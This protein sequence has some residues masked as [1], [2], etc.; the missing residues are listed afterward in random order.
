MSP[1]PSL[2]CMGICGLLPGKKGQSIKVK[3]KESQI[4]GETPKIK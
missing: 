3:T 4:L 1:K 2:A